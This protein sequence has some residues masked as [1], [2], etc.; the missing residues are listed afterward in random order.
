MGA[1]PWRPPRDPNLPAGANAASVEFSSSLIQWQPETRQCV[2][3]G[4]FEITRYRSSKKGRLKLWPGP[5]RKNCAFSSRSLFPLIKKDIQGLLRGED[6]VA[7]RVEQIWRVSRLFCT[8]CH[9]Q[10]CDSRD[11]P[12]R[13]FLPRPCLSR[14]GGWGGREAGGAGDGAPPRPRQPIPHCCCCRRIGPI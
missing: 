5:G 14:S 13:V 3:A 1:K 11:Q 6:I 10:C 8:V 9:L 4:C 7:D 2:E 12:P